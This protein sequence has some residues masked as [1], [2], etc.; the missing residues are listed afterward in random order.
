M[1]LRLVSLA[2]DDESHRGKALAELTYIALLA[3]TSPIYEHLAHLDLFD[4]FISADNIMANKDYKHVFK[5]LCNTLLQE[6]GSIVHGMRLTCGL[7][8][9]H[10]RDIECSNAHIEHILNPTNKQDVVL[11]YT[12]LKDLWSF[13][14]ADSDT[15]NQSY[16]EVPNALHLY[17]QFSYHLIFPY[18]CTELSLSN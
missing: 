17:G 9:K 10:L 13:P 12:L 7:I 15:R 5:C 11:S 3:P 14:S 16:I 4:L 1:K 8:C 18:I 2:S 6:E